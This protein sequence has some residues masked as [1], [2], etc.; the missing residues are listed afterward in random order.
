MS[1]VGLTPGETYL[2][3]ANALGALGASDW[4]SVQTMMV[5]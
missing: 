2:V 1:F 5:I 4:S 3:Q